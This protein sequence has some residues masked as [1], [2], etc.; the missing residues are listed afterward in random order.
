MTRPTVT[1]CICTI[2]GRESLLERAVASV[3]AQTVIP[4]ALVIHCDLE[5]VGAA[6]ARNAALSQ[7]RTEYVGWLDDDDEMLPRHLEA[8]LAVAE[9]TSA[10]VVYPWMI[11]DPPHADNLR[12]VGP[13]RQVTSPLGVPFSDEMR[14][15]L[16][17][18]HNFL[19]LTGLIRAEA[20]RRVG[21]FVALG[22]RGSEEDAGLYQALAGAGASFV[23]VPERTWIWHRGA[24]S[25]GGRGVKGYGG[26]PR[27]RGPLDFDV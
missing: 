19:H 24:Q 27:Q 15:Q 10:D 16:E 12:C 17:V 22:P 18:G 6:S 21:G 20:I 5:R 23:H 3:A 14:R 9:T 8:C 26:A 2:P 25:T 13:E 4:D 7:A 1:V 11:V